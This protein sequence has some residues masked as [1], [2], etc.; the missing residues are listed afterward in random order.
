MIALPPLMRA[1]AGPN[2]LTRAAQMARAGTDA[3]LLCWSDE[4]GR[5]DAALVLVPDG[6]AGPALAAGMVA[7]R[8]AL[9][10]LAPPEMAVTGTWDGI[11]RVEGAAAGGVELYA[12]PPWAILRLQIDLMPQNDGEPGTAPDRTALWLEGCGDITA[13]DLLSAFARH[14][15]FHLSRLE[16]DQTGLFRDWHAMLGGASIDADGNLIQGAGLRKLS[17]QIK[18]I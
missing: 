12:H 8:D 5:L 9:G 6:P 18:D 7:L 13:P 17:S 16:D 2:P 1:D 4:G 15:L 11:I 14:V 3:G 10:V